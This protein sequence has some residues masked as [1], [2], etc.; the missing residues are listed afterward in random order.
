MAFFDYIDLKYT[1][2]QN[3]TY[4]Y[5]KNTYSRSTESYS[6]ASP[7]GQV[8]NFLNNLFQWNIL[9]QKRVISNFIITEADNQKAIRNLARIGGWIF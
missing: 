7:F 1:E 8:I 6:N 3:Q 2:L 4:T 5:L 9:S